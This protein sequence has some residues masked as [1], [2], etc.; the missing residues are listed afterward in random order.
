LEIYIWGLLKKAHDFKTRIGGEVRKRSGWEG[1]GK[2]E[3][4]STFA[5]GEMR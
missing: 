3:G 1:I 2:L 5:W 4:G